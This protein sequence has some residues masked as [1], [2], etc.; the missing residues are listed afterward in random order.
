MALTR[1]S[2]DGSIHLYLNGV[3]TTRT[4]GVVGSVTDNDIT[5]TNGAGLY[6]G[7][8]FR[9]TIENRSYNNTATVDAFFDDLRISTASRYTSVGISTTTTFTPSTTALETTGT[10]TSSY[11]P[12]GN[13]RGVIA[14]GASPSWKGSPG[15]TVS[16]QSSGNYRVSF[17]TSYISNLDYLVLSQ[18][19]DQGYASYVGIARSTEHVDISVN[20]QSD[21][22][23]VDTG[24]LSVQIT[25]L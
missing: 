10:L 23:A 19:A 4:S 20:K 17:A 15:C 22:S 9:D 11:T 13:K 24:Y 21:D 5:S 18:A 6:I 12:P 8:I 2:S 3:E 25:N 14:L 16:Q 1:E 7:G